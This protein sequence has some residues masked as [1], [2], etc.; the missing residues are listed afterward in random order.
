M[1]DDDRYLY[2]IDTGLK[3]KVKQSAL[4]ND[5][6]LCKVI[7]IYLEDYFTSGTHRIDI[8]GTEEAYGYTKDEIHNHLLSILRNPISEHKC[9][10]RPKPEEW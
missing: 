10:N 2:G 6:E 4:N 1:R 5:C 3:N 9:V 8:E 7:L